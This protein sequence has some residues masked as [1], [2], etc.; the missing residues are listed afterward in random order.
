[1]TRH[2]FNV[3]LA[4]TFAL[5]VCV[6]MAGPTDIAPQVVKAF[7]GGTMIDGTGADPIPGAIIIVAGDRIERVDR[8]AELD[9][10]EGIQTIDV[11]GKW[12]IPGLIDA[13][14]HFFQSAS[15]YTRPDV[16]DL[17]R[18]RPYSEEITWLRDRIPLT[19]ARYIASGVTSVVDLA[20]PAWTFEV[21]EYAGRSPLAPLV[22][23]TGPGLAPT[24][25]EALTNDDPPGINVRTPR[26]ACEQVR[27]LLERKPDLLKIWSPYSSGMDLDQ[28]MQWVGAA[29]EEAH[30]HGVRV[31]VHATQRELAREMVKAGVDILVQS[32]GSITH[33]SRDNP[34]EKQPSRSRLCVEYPRPCHRQAASTLPA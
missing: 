24:M 30:A 19:L 31:G 20:G 14:V 7:V 8:S 21:R 9:L 13:Y 22:S 12:V 23:I 1:M 10:P 26:Q 15:L 29:V 11:T 28:E 18:V 2:P 33:A 3:F 17:R 16:I 6:V 5:T 34:A 25:S 32:I 4:A 27:R